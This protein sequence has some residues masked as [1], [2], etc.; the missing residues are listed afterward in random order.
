M[1]QPS[2]AKADK[3]YKKTRYASHGHGE[4]IPH[5]DVLKGTVQDCL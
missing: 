5:T 2:M 4:C 1:A 3:V